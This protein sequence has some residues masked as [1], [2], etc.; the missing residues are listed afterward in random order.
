M[1]QKHTIFS[2][3]LYESSYSDSLQPIITGCKSLAQQ[4]DFKV[5]TS[6]N[7]GLQS[8]DDLHNVPFIF[9]LMEWICHEAETVFSELG[10]DK[11]YLTIE[12]SWFNINNQ[13]NSFNQ[14]HLHPGIV[15]GVFYLQAPEGSGNINFRNSGMNELWRGHRESVG[16]RNVHNASNFTITPMPGKLY[17][18]PSYMYHSVDTNSINVERM[19]IGFN[20]G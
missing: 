4:S 13:L 14:T 6:A 11:E 7:R 8:Q 18:W 15:S 17:L 20:L 19:S 2:T 1:M 9:P 10:I 3:P 16:A 5:V 12:S